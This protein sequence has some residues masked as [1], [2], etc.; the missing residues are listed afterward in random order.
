MFLKHGFNTTSMDDVV[1]QSGVSKSNIYYHF[2]SKDELAL[3]V[4]EANIAMLDGFY[5]QASGE[6]GAAGK[7]RRYT[8]LLIGELTGR[9]CAG[10][11]PLMSLMVEAGKTN[12]AVRVRLE[13]FFE[14]QSV[15]AAP[16][17]RKEHG[18]EK[19]A[20]ISPPVRSLL[21]SCLGWKVR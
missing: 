18:R 9:D 11:C 16:C 1:K 5:E 8:D 2:K 15:L 19:S 4:L 17:L 3:A 20:E 7:L 6:T 10:G 21:C 12:E 14:E 13:R